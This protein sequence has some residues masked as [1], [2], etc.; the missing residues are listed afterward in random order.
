MIASSRLESYVKREL[1]NASRCLP[2]HTQLISR[3]MDRWMDGSLQTGL[4]YTCLSRTYTL[5]CAYIYVRV[6]YVYVCRYAAL[7]NH[8]PR[9]RM[10][11]R[12]YV[13][14]RYVCTYLHNAYI[15][16]TTPCHAICTYLRQPLPQRSR[17]SDPAGRERA[18]Q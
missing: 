9:R 12:I 6:M 5:P 3:W 16:H 8:A 2:R 1:H 10:P 18:E 7:I 11:C 15:T 4:L 13:G 17:R 14:P